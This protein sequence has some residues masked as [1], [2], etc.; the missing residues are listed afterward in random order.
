MFSVTKLLVVL[1]VVS[2]SVSV[3]AAT[4]LRV[5]ADPNNLPFSN[6]VQQGFENHLAQ[7]IAKDL[8]MQLSYDWF[9]Q[10]SAFFRKTLN[11]GQCDVVMG[12]PSEIPV[13]STTIPYYR[14]SYVFVTRRASHLDLTSMDDP[15]LHQLRIGVHITGDQDSNLP[16]V[17]ALLS[18]G[19]VR[20]LVG[21][22]IY[23]NLSETNPPSDLIEAVAHKDVDIAIA[24]GPMAGYFARRASIPLAVTPVDV[25][26]PDPKMPFT[27]A[28]SMGV[29]HGDQ[30]LLQ[31]LNAE[32]QRREPQI[33]QILKSYGVPLLATSPT[34][35]MGN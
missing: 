16:P 2:A 17:N 6:R 14:S 15:R 8:D 22:S 35:R 28:I 18:R 9:P 5:C 20:N 10:R 30:A 21:Y 13:A 3:A 4:T 25:V 32:I 19:I 1:T 34:V 27:F 26:S 33:R 7:M 31:Q 12:V 29:R 24:W 11:S 23:G